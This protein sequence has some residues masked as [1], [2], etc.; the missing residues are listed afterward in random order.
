MDT[1]TVRLL[2]G[3]LGLLFLVAMAVPYWRICQRTGLSRGLAVLIVVPIV[4][5]L[6]PWIIAFSNWPKVPPRPQP[7][8]PRNGVVYTASE[9]EDFKRQGLM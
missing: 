3:V 4:G 1:S 9:L 8:G 5:A 7:N 2:F 6:V